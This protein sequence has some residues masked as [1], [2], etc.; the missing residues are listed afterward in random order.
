MALQPN[1]TTEVS[2]AFN[3]AIREPDASASKSP[4]GRRLPDPPAYWV[5]RTALA[6]ALLQ[7]ENPKNRLPADTFERHVHQVTARVHSDRMCM[8]SRVP[9]Q[10][11]QRIP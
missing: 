8:R 2:R 1:A 4:H 9:W 3:L 6:E 10:R 5:H 11:H 7:A